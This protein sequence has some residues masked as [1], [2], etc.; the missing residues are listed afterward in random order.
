MK[1]DFTQF[2]QSNYPKSGPEHFLSF[3]LDFILQNAPF[4]ATQSAY[5]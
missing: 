4:D 5:Q 2:T 3:S 1:S